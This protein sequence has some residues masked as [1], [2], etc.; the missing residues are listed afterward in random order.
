VTGV[1][2]LMQKDTRKRREVKEE[3]INMDMADCSHG[4][5]LARP[6]RQL[7]GGSV[8]SSLVN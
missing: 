7:K 6:L 3:E 2:G 5:L 4:R 8:I 1:G